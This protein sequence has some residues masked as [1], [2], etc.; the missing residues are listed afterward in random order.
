VLEIEQEDADPGNLS[1]NYVSL[2][3]EDLRALAAALTKAA[4]ELAS[5]KAGAEG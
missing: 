4:D 3:E 5:M 1:G 2:R